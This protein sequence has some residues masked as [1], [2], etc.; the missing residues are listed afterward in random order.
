MSTP[1][2]SIMKR[3]LSILF[4]YFILVIFFSFS[5]SK[6]KEAYFYYAFDEKVPLL[7][8]EGS[9]VLA[10]DIEPDTA[11]KAADIAEVIPRFQIRWKDSRTAI[12]EIDKQADSK[13]IMEA[14]MLNDTSVNSIQPLYRLEEGNEMPVTD[15]FVI[16]FPKENHSKIMNMHKQYRLEVLQT[17]ELF[18]LLKVP[19]G[20]D[21]LQI[22][23]NYQE[24]GLVRFSHPDF[25]VFAEPYQT[26][27]NDPYFNNQFYLRNTGQ[28]FNTVENHSGTAGADIKVLD[29]WETTM[30]T[31]SIVVA[32]LD[33][34]VTS[35]HPDLPNT[36]Q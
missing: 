10:Y 22:A 28:I 26:I 14:I 31:N 6:R 8:V 3:Y 21:A 25:I 15:V 32:V 16:G 23:N 13:T 19:K 9:F 34:G 12:I 1:N 33:Y 11:K 20:S 29:A 18:Q 7:K 27:P 36:R 5:S 30:G 17:N 24:S 35:D 2:L 4:F